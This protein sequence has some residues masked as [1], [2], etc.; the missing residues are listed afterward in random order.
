MDF[1][2]VANE[3]YIAEDYEGAIEGYSSAISALPE[4]AIIYE[5]RAAAYLKLKK[6]MNALEDCNKSIKIEPT[7]RCYF[8]KGIALFSLEDYE[9]SKSSFKE[10]LEL[11]KT[12]LQKTNKSYLNQFITEYNRNIRKCDSELLQEEE[13]KK[14]KKEEEDKKKKTNN[15][16]NNNNNNS[17]NSTINTAVPTLPLGG[18]KY[19]YYQSNEKLTIDVLIKHMD[20][21]NVD[22]DIQ[23]DS[24]KVVC[25]VNEISEV[26]ID[27]MLYD[28]VVVDK[29]KVNVK[30]TKI[31]II[32]VK[33]H[34][35]EWSS[36]DNPTASTTKK[37]IE[38]N[39][40]NNNNNDIPKENNLP[41]PYASHKDW[42]KIETKITEELEAEKPEGEEALQ[43]L[44]KDIYAKASPETRRAMNKSYQTSGG[45]TLSTNWDEVSKTD[46]EENRQAPK[47]VEWKNWE[48]KK[49]P[50]KEDN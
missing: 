1:Y 22:V 44:F 11:C 16:N 17:V 33:Q 41:K 12:L 43:K 34:P 26:V 42:N 37:K 2:K 36:L 4:K 15:N 23:E 28:Q 31:E 19:Q 18:I 7:E 5:N 40:S 45:T 29:C 8:R 21:K 39:N 46:Y 20:P 3:L 35:R 27:K 48:G 9:S 32:L 25:T 47:G 24:L 49:L 14:K 38:N 30:K 6:Y 10:G 13:E 50:M